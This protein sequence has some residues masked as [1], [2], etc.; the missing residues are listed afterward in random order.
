MQNMVRQDKLLPQKQFE[1]T[2]D[3]AGKPTLSL[4]PVLTAHP[5]RTSNPALARSTTAILNAV[6]RWQK[7]AS[8][9]EAAQQ[10][11]RGLADGFVRD[12]PLRAEKPDVKTEH[13]EVVLKKMDETVKATKLVRQHMNRSIQFRTWCAGDHDGHPGVLAIDLTKA[14]IDRATAFLE[15]CDA[16]LSKLEKAVQNI[17]SPPRDIRLGTAIEEIKTIRNK[18]ASTRNAIAT[19]TVEEGVARYATAAKFQQDIAKLTEAM[20]ESKTLKNLAFRV[21][22]FGLHYAAVDLRQNSSVFEKVASDLYQDH[23]PGEPS[24]GGMSD[25]A[26]V[27]TLKRLL[28]NSKAGYNEKSRHDESTK[29]EM[30]LIKA[31]LEL[32]KRVSPDAHGYQII[33]NTESQSDLL[34]AMLAVKAAGGY[35]PA[36]KELAMPIVPLFETIDDLKEAPAIMEKWFDTLKELDI[37]MPNGV[38]PIMVGYSDSNKGGGFVPSRWAVFKAVQELA[39]KAASV[40]RKL[41]IFHGN[42]G[43]EARGGGDL[44]KTMEARHPVGGSSEWT[45]QGEAFN[46]MIPSGELGAANLSDLIAANDIRT[47]NKGSMPENHIKLLDDLSAKCT[48][49]YHTLHNDKAFVDVIEALQRQLF[50][51]GLL[52]AGSRPAARPSDEKEPAKRLSAMRAINH[53][54]PTAALRSSFQIVFGFGTALSEMTKENPGKEKELK[55]L[56]RDSAVFRSMITDMETGMAKAHPGMVK[57]MLESLSKDVQVSAKQV[58]EAWHADLKLGEKHL[59]EITGQNYL[60]EKRPEEKRLLDKRLAIADACGALTIKLAKERVSNPD[61]V[62]ATHLA[63]ALSASMAALQNAA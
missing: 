41:S 51:T 8:T 21:D 32:R 4:V 33:A 35:D 29:N 40:D 58:G 10:Q 43:S 42:G 55:A 46:N 19:G 5:T 37:H 22:N 36:T 25:D 63:K 57:A 9:K 47:K 30:A 38:Q 24:Y 1:H 48:Q 17:K 3:V 39:D 56:H 27:E 2:G 28:T 20:S 7:D 45:V 62:S 23:S 18:L 6:A 60:M 13:A 52:N 15:K 11:M 61:Q 16:K 12:A 59:L 44:A 50:P 31:A 34:E 53:N 54:I 14:A 49:A 26:R